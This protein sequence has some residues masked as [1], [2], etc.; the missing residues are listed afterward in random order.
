MRCLARLEISSELNLLPRVNKVTLLY[1]Y[2]ENIVYEKN[3]ITNKFNEYFTNIGPNLSNKIKP[4][5]NKSFHQYLSQ[6]YTDKF[7]FQNVNEQ[8]IL[9]IIDKLAPKCRCRFG[10][11]SSKIIK[12]LKVSQTKPITLII[13]QILNTG[14]F[15]DKLKFAKI[16]PIYKKDD[17]TLFTSGKVAR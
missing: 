10:G 8:D 11:I 13:N 3:V 2:G 16:I 14:I 9:L 17:E 4:L 6:K 5:R 15:P 12:M 7:N 1:F